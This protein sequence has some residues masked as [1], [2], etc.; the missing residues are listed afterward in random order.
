MGGSGEGR[1][2]GSGTDT[3]KGTKAHKSKRILLDLEV[4]QVLGR[5]MVPVIT[6]NPGSSKG[7]ELLGDTSLA[8]VQVQIARGGKGTS[9][10]AP[11]PRVNQELIEGH[12]E[13]QALKGR[14]V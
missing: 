9:G 1:A 12:C 14:E 2:K 4:K 5:V 10:V 11:K 3:T 6:Q 8:G 7:N 13:E